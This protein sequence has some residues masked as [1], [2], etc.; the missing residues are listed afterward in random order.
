MRQ[1]LFDGNTYLKSMCIVNTG[2]NYEAARQRCVQLGMNLFIIDDSRV[3]RPFFEATTWLLRGHPNGFTWINGRRNNLTGWQVFN[4]DNTL[5]GPLYSGVDWV[6]TTNVNGPTNGDCLR[7]SSQF[8]PYQAMGI[9]CTSSSWLICEHSMQTEQPPTTTT[10][11]TTPAPT[12]TTPPSGPNLAACW[13][14]ADL[15]HN[16]TY[17]KSSCIINTSQNYAGAE[18]ACRTNRMELFAIDSPQVQTQFRNSTRQLLINNPRGFVWIN[19]RVD[20]E[21]R[22]WYTFTPQRNL[23]FSAV[24]WVQQESFVGR[25]TGDCLRYT[26]QYT[27]DYFA[28]GVACTSASWFICEFSVPP[29]IVP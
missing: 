29:V 16:G 22:N 21:C 17:L 24:H 11:T 26:Q 9:A 15:F 13:R 19:G 28:M 5:R 10:T 18:Q 2:T 14:R 20:D 1:D 23:M 25:N 8:G 27:E 3:Q 4:A 7:Y 12:T 6:N